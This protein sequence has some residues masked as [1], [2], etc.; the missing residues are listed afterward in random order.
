M[1]LFQ[2]KVLI[3]K[4][5]VKT[6]EGSILLPEQ[7]TDFEP[8]TGT[9]VQVGPGKVFCV[10]DKDGIVTVK[11]AAK[12]SLKPG[13]KVMCQKNTEYEIKVNDEWLVLVK[14]GDVIGVLDEIT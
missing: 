4:D 5:P 8:F 12:T 10:R 9:V 6:Q 1:I 11:G 7:R 3:K 2:D 13:N 14:E